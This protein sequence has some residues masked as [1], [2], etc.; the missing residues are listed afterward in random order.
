MTNLFRSST[1]HSTGLQQAI[2]KATDGNQSTEDWSLIMKI[3]D[4]V[5]TREESA[6]EAMKA[7][8]KRLQ[9]N[10]VQHGWRTIGLT[11]TLLEA[12]TKNCGK[13]FHVQIAH[14]DFLKELKGVIGPKNNPPPAIQERVLGMIQTWAL[15]FRQDPDLKN[16]EHFYTECIQHGLQFPPAEPENIIKAS[17]TPTRTIERPLQ[18]T[19]SMPPQEFGTVSGQNRSASDGYSYSI[20][21]NQTAVQSMSAEQLAKLRSEL[22]VVQTNVQVFGEML[23]TLQPSEENPQDFELL[24]VKKFYVCNLFKTF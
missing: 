7:I 4:H 1:H 3:C 10:P 14:K 8:R 19:R 17:L 13:L 15:A 2:E 12:L 23:V 22:D 21:N 9:L 11:L 18:N 5:G 6:K 16:V 24:M 20:A